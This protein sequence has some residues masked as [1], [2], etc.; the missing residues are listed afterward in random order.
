MN[1]SQFFIEIDSERLYLS[2]LEN[3]MPT[4]FEDSYNVEVRINVKIR[5]EEDYKQY[6][7]FDRFIN[8]EVTVGIKYT[9]GL[10]FQSTFT[11]DKY[12]RRFGNIK[13]STVTHVIKGAK[14][15]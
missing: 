3:P 2:N 14:R 11:V 12:E 13:D 9:N 5:D 1:N 7:S 4:I 10:E 8:K 6:A 15:H